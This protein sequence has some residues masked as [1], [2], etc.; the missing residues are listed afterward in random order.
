MSKATTA[1]YVIYFIHDI[2]N[3]QLYC[4]TRTQCHADMHYAR[5][6]AMIDVN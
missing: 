2:L 1:I 3:L 6:H 5:G 4:H